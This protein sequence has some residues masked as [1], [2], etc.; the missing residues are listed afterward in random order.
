MLTALFT[1]LLSQAIFCSYIFVCTQDVDLAELHLYGKGRCFGHARYPLITLTD[2]KKHWLFNDYGLINPQIQWMLELTKGHS[3][4]CDHPNFPRTSLMPTVGWTTLLP[5]PCHQLPLGLV[6]QAP[7]SPLHRW[8]RAG[9]AWRLM[10]LLPAVF[11][12][13]SRWAGHVSGS[14]TLPHGPWA[15]PPPTPGH[16][17]GL[18]IGMWWPKG[19]PVCQ[20]PWLGHVASLT[21]AK[22]N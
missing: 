17:S 1:F 14:S 20:E 21:E 6:P 19:L 15:F 22:I 3:E 5:E 10:V 7:V 2:A 13:G 11:L 18:A 12:Q 9:V 8:S 4:Y 16:L